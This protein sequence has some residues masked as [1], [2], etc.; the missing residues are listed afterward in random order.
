MHQ[1]SCAQGNICDLA[2]GFTVVKRFQANNLELTVAFPVGEARFL[3]L[4]YVDGMTREKHLDSYFPG[5]CLDLHFSP[6]TCCV[7]EMRQLTVDYGKCSIGRLHWINMN[8]AT[9]DKHQDTTILQLYMT[10][11]Y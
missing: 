4:A 6:Q 2:G 3:G 11:R 7:Y 9:H 10:C 8:N 1:H 5:F